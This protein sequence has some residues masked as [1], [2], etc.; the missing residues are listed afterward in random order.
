MSKPENSAA[1]S[2]ESHGSSEKLPDAFVCFAHGSQR[3]RRY[4][5]IGGDRWDVHLWVNQWHFFDNISDSL[6][7]EDFEDALE[8]YQ[9]AL[10][11]GAGAMLNALDEDT[12]TCE[13]C[14]RASDDGSIEFYEDSEGGGIWCCDDCLDS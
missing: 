8:V 12:P 10:R 2:D 7:I 1:V 4:T 5:R 9:F 14:E 11:R 6:A 3:P 13:R